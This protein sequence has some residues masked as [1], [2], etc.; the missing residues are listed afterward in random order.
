MVQSEIHGNEKTGTVALVNM[1]KQ[2]ATNN[3]PKY[4]QLREEITILQCQ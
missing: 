2:L 4:K 1:L 3:S